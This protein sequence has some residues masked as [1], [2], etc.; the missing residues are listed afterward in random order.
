[1]SNRNC[2]SKRLSLINLARQANDSEIETLNGVAVEK[3]KAALVNCNKV[4]MGGFAYLEIVTSQIREAIDLLEN[5]N[6]RAAVKEAQ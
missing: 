3:L 6:A 1:M 2:H 4:K 5:A